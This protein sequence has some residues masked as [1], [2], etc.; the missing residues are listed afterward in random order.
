MITLSN[1]GPHLLSTNYWETAIERAGKVFCSVNA[2]AVRVLLP[3][4]CADEML[5]EMRTGNVVVIS[6][7][8]WPEQG[9]PDAV[10]MMW[11]DESDAPF[12]LHLS[13]ESFDV[14]PGNPGDDHWTVTVWVHGPRKVL[15]QQATW[16]RVKQIPCL[17][18]A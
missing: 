14:L 17:V 18:P 9:L 1:D 13:P 5:A 11:D 7:G 3:R 8:S 10:E 15:E 4:A 6:R 12:A 16:R 2:G